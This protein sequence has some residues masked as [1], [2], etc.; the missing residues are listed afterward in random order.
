MILRSSAA[1]GS[2]AVLFLAACG[3][4]STEASGASA[5]ASATSASHQGKPKPRVLRVGTYRGVKGPYSTIQAAVDAAGPGDWVLVGP[6]EYHETGAPDSGVLITTPGIRGLDRNGVIV[7]GT[8]PGHGACSADSAA[9]NPGP[10][11]GSGV[12]IGRNGIQVLEVDGVSIENLTACNFLS[13]SGGNGN[14]IWFNGGDGSGSIGMG[15]YRGAYLTASSTF[16]HGDSGYVAQ[17]GIFASNASGPGTIEESYA[18]N[19][20]DSSFYVGACR[21][22]NA[23]L[24][25]LHAQNSAL[26]FSGSNAGGHLV[27]E[28]SEWDHNRTGILPNSLANDD[29]PS[30]QDGS[31]PDKPGRSCTLIRRNHV[32]DNNNPNT[33]ALGLTAGAPVGTGIDLSGGRN[34]TVRDNLVENNGAWGVLVNDYPDPTGPEVPAYC[35]GGVVDFEPPPPY[36]AFFGAIFGPGVPCY[37]HAFGNRILDNRLMANGTF[38]NDTNGDLANATLPY[39]TNNCFDGN[40][41]PGAGAPTTAPADLQD[42]SVAGTCGAS[43]EGDPAQVMALF[44]QALCAAYGLCPLGGTYPQPTQVAMLPI[45]RNLPGMKNPCKGVPRNPWCDDGEGDDRGA[46]N[47]DD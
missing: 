45:P 47:G 34:N 12:A 2:L 30:P 17:Y 43:W 26:G 38:G 3:Q 11:D 35:A 41:D 22:C 20:A 36:D 15:S 32:H 9:Q 33:P 44:A 4:R 8:L 29:P 40:V 39:P 16:F 18:S 27:I 7:D 10:L 31:C 37:F 1:V 46:G 13:G 24:R 14:E 23:V 19:M 6:G 25:R 42:P 5:S 21:D 28:D